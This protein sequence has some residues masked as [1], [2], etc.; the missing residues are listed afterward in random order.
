MKNRT[1]NI[2]L[3]ALILVIFI[4]YF[5]L[6]NFT[7]T[8]QISEQ[9]MQAETFAKN[10]NWDGVLEVTKELKDKWSRQKHLLMFNFAEAEFALFEN[11]LSYIIGGAE[12]KQLDTTLGNIAAAKDLWKNFVK[13]VPEP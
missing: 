13:V 10:E 7:F 5:S 8:N 12:G 4:G 1:I 3:I 9:L 2:G 6:L 11:H